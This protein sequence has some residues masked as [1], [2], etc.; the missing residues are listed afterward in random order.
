MMH[1]V[2]LNGHVWLSIRPAAADTVHARALRVRCPTNLQSKAWR[3]R[4]EQV[5]I[6]DVAYGDMF[7]GRHAG[8]MNIAPMHSMHSIIS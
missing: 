2:L 1:N 3:A 7:I 4:I 8:R 5:I 6:V